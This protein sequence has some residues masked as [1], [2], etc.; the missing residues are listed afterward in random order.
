ME[1]IPNGWDLASIIALTFIKGLTYNECTKIINK[2]ASFDD[3]SKNAFNL[4]QGDFFENESKD[5]EGISVMQ[6]SE[7]Q[8]EFAE[9]NNYKIITIWNDAYPSLLKQIE[10]PP[11]VLY[12]WGEL[13]HADAI[14]ISV[15]GTRK[16]TYYGKIVTEQFVSEFVKQNLLITSGMANGIDYIAHKTAIKNNGITYALIASG[17]DKINSHASI[18]IANDIVASGGTIISEYKFGTVALPGYFLHRNRIISGISKAT[19]VVES[20]YKGGSLNTAKFADMQSRDVF[21]IPGN[22]TSEKSSGTNNLIRRH[23]A[24]IAISPKTMLEDMGLLEIDYKSDTTNQNKN[25]FHQNITFA[26]PSE[27]K[28]YNNL[29]N[30]PLHIDALIGLT[31]L[32]ISEILVQ[33]IDMEFNGLVKQL[34]GKHYIKNISL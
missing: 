21:V 6:K 25:N 32:D 3:F 11:I 10:Y 4:R 29:S 17:L 23:K 1:N 20:A 13:Q 22:I 28:I 24:V 19:L 5:K 12:I 16:C 27:E 7:K 9:K 15:V 26:N 30:E 33:L 18:Q 34:P 8:I 31:G 14:S 2:Y